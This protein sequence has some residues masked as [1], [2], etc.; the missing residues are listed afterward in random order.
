MLDNVNNGG[1]IAMLGIRGKKMA[2]LILSW[3]DFDAM[4]SGQSGKVTLNWE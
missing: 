2:S 1:K 4:H 3:V